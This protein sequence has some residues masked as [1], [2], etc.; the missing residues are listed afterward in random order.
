[1]ADIR[2]LCIS[3]LH[4]GADNSLLTN[5]RPGTSE[6]DPTQPS[7]VLVQLAECL[8]SLATLNGAR[9]KP[10]LILNGDALELAL[11]LDN[12][13]AMAFER[14]LEVLFPT[15]SEPL[16]D[17][18]IIFI[19]GNHDHHLWETARE[20]QYAQ[21][22][23]NILPGGFLE[24]PWH[25]TK[26]FKPDFVSA[27]L[28]NSVIHRYERMV[29]RGVSVGT[30]YPNLVLLNKDETRCAIFTHGH[31]VESIYKL[32]SELRTSLFPDE[33]E[34]IQIWDLEGENFAWID[35]FWSTM[36]RSGAV[37][38]DIERVYEMLLVPRTRRKLAAQLA[39][40]IG[41]A[42]MPKLPSVGERLA[43]VLVPVINSFLG[44]ASGL[45]KGKAD[46]P[47]T[48]DASAGFRFYV[49]ELLLNQLML[50]RKDTMPVQAAIIFGHTHKPF[51]STQNFK[52]F[53]EQVSVFNT[54]GWVVDAPATESS[55]GA[56]IVLVDDDWNLAAL[57][58]YNEADD[59]HSYAV[60]VESA[61]GNPAANPLCNQLDMVLKAC[62]KQ[63]E[64]LSTVIAENVSTYHRNFANRLR[65][66]AQSG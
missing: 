25:T 54:G 6:V 65:H 35:F 38:A 56:S 7:A 59:P 1:M 12:K 66:I 39:R 13:A 17:S 50:E 45:E 34:P 19:P 58:V 49:E 9:R 41:R 20:T 47:L 60:K 61:D 48:G 24:P 30:V 29:A 14:F 37:G 2:Y 44:K 52:G 64:S 4:L 63:W 51:A 16:V 15:N 5:L 10:T 40:A 46:Q 3:D 22:L 62:R 32:M 57:R 11:A 23:G 21:F 28:L 36:G 33:H 31:F 42:W 55:H 43:L 26:M 18:Q 8:N 53:P 27:T